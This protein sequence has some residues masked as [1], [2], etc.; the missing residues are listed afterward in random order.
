M[1]RFSQTRLSSMRIATVLASVMAF[2]VTLSST[3]STGLCNAFQ[4]PVAVKTPSRYTLSHKT[5]MRTTTSSSRVPPT[6]L[7][8]RF[9]FHS[10]H[11]SHSYS[12][13]TFPSPTSLYASDNDD[14]ATGG[15][16][17]QD[18]GMLVWIHGIVTSVTNSVWDTIFGS[19]SSSNSRMI[20]LDVT[21]ANSSSEK[22][23]KKE[24]IELPKRPSWKDPRSGFVQK[25]GYTSIEDWNEKNSK[26]GDTM[27]EQRVQFEGLRDGNKMRQNDI[28]ERS[29]KFIMK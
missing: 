18:L 19:S 26:A 23:K 11:S 2:L 15:N 10:R 5:I 13:T 1:T 28:L 21:P 16:D 29:M 17:Q 7:P 25:S 24:R 4:I 20:T 9:L 14:E 8:V 27:W 12:S 6:A 3:Y 22:K